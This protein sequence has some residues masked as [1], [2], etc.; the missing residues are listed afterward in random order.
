M[1][2]P[3]THL[4]RFGARDYDPV[5]GRWVQRDPIL[6]A[7]RD[8]NLYQYC[9]ADPVN[10]IDPR[11]TDD[12][13]GLTHIDDLPYLWWSVVWSGIPNVLG[14]VVGV[15]G[16]GFNADTGEQNTIEFYDNSI[17]DAVNPGGATTFGHVICYGGSSP[18]DDQRIHEGAHVQQSDWLGP[19]YLQAHGAAQIW[20]H[21]LYAAFGSTSQP[22][23]D[24]PY[25]AYNPGEWGPYS[26][27]PTP[28]PW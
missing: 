20:S 28:W 10:R 22:G 4:V 13:M 1:W 8:T 19:V 26:P 23:G 15:A 3:L 7:G 24:D 2:D 21:A 27:S 18:S 12:E 16:S 11:G 17:I 9:G 25:S 5:T 14:T 6:F